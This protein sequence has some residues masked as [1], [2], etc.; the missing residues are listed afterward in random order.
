MVAGPWE[1]IEAETLNKAICFLS[2]LRNRTPEGAPVTNGDGSG[3][4]PNEPQGAIRI[5]YIMELREGYK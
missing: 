4:E 3:R 5:M 2:H 1:A